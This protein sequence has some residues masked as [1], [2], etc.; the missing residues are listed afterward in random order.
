MDLLLPF[1]IIIILI[2]LNG[3]FVAAEF[4]IIGVRPT[5]IKQLADEGNVVAKRLYITMKDPGKVDRYIASAQLGITLASLGLGMYGEPIIAGLIEPPLHD[6]FGLEGDIVHTI[7]F[8][9]ALGLITYLHVVVGEM[10]PKSISLQN[11]ERTI[12]ILARP[13]LIMQTIF[14]Y[15]IT[16]LNYIGVLVLRLM[17]IPP[18]DSGSRLITPDELELIVSE[19]VV[20]GLIEPQEQE[21][22]NSIFDFGD[23]YVVQMMTPRPKMTAIPLDVSEAELLETVTTAPHTRFPVY[24]DSLDKIVGIVHLRDVVEQQLDEKPFDI[25]SMMHEV[26]FIPETA[27]AEALLAIFK[28]QHIHM[29]VVIDEFGGTAGI[30]TLEDLIEEI[31]GE[32]RDEFDSHEIEPITVVEPGHLLVQGTVRLDEIADYV[33]LGEEHDEV[34][35]IGGLMMSKLNLPPSVG[36]E[37]TLNGVTL[38]IEEVDGLATERVSIHFSPDAPDETGENTD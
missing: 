17:R 33:D 13:M 24:E 23:L 11:A 31:V 3:M 34:D 5:R 9:M 15:P 18:P 27:S 25:R 19:S 22:I 8:L 10:V 21:L 35:T 4:A 26:P 32:V 16:A 6:W 30:A 7:G 37:L 20:G 36:E 12:F 2:L 1:T 38:R 28:E 14:A 29:A